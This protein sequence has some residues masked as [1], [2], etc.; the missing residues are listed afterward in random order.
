MIS[1]VIATLDDEAVLGRALQP[2]LAAAI[3]GLVSE[4]IVVD[5]GSTDATIEIADDAGCRIIAGEGD[6]ASRQD[7]GVAAARRDWVLRLDAL[8]WLAP[9]WDAA[10]RD[11]IERHP[12]RAAVFPSGGAGWMGLLGLGPRGPRALLEPRAGGGHPARCLKSPLI[13]PQL[14]RSLKDQPR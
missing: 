12:G 6:A 4:V 5:G 7:A 9:A 3:S 2:L 13:A 11:H 8:A 1:V 10:A 14:A